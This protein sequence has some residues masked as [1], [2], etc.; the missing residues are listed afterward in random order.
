MHLKA[1]AQIPALVGVQGLQVLPRIEIF[2]LRSRRADSLQNALV[3]ELILHE[4]LKLLL[5]KVP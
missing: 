3:I 4:K 5:G 1:K 2:L